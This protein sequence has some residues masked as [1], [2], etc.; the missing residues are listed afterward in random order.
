MCGLYKRVVEI[1]EMKEKYGT[2]SRLRKVFN[3]NPKLCDRNVYDFGCV[4]QKV[5]TYI[6]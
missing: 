5:K 4:C 2:Q 6:R 1:A 3:T